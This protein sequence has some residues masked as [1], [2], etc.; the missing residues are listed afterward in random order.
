[1]RTVHSPIS[2]LC[3]KQLSQRQRRA[4]SNFPSRAEQIDL[5]D[6]DNTIPN[7]TAFLDFEG[8]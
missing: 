1:M 6:F 5:Q 8:F 2:T 7:P 3:F 4:M